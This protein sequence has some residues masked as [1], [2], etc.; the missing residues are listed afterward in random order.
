MSPKF[1]VKVDPAFDTVIDANLTTPASWHK[2]AGFYSHASRTL[3]STRTRT[4][5]PKTRLGRKHMSDFISA[6][7]LGEN[8]RKRKSTD[9]SSFQDK[10]NNSDSSTVN[11][12][13]HHTSTTNKS[14][15]LNN[16]I[17]LATVESAH[18]DKPLD[19]RKSSG[20]PR[21]QS[22]PV[23]QIKRQYLYFSCI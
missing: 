12:V 17:T 3:T 13:H 20:S 6:S 14:S 18:A 15:K 5:S 9:S 22:H 11:Q 7:N 19:Q 4:K 21:P 10:N 8:T 2:R 23:N 1:H 16:Y